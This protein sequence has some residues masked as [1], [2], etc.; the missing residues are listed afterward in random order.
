MTNRLP[1]AHPMDDLGALWGLVLV[2]GEIAVRVAGQ[3][4]QAPTADQPDNDQE[5][6][7]QEAA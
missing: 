1:E 6:P 3:E 2:L 5:P 4:V 7:G